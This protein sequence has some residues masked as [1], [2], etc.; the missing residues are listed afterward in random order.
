MACSQY[1]AK[2]TA[3]PMIPAG[4]KR[5]V[6]DAGALEAALRCGWWYRSW[7]SMAADAINIAADP[8]SARAM[9]RALDVPAVEGALTDS[10]EAPLQQS[11]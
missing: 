6:L 11:S 4:I 2:I 8:A 5:A 9:L 10:P 1:T 3:M 7:P